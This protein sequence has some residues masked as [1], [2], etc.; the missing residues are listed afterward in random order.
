[1]KDALLLATA[2][3]YRPREHE[4][5]R[6]DVGDVRGA[7]RVL[8]ARYETTMD[9]MARFWPL[10]DRVAAVGTLLARARLGHRKW[11]AE[12]FAPY[13]PERRGALHDRRLAELVGATE[14]YTWQ[15][16]RRR[17]GVSAATAEQAIAETLLALVA[18]WGDERRKSDG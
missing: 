8:A 18:H 13:L 6:V 17:M 2:R 16:W 5:R 15:L 7:A 10:E 14:L 1:S 9:M 3:K 11:L 12:T 4:G